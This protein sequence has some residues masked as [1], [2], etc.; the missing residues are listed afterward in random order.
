MSYRLSVCEEIG[1]CVETEVVHV[2]NAAQA[3]LPRQ[4]LPQVFKG[5]LLVF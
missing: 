1:I 3:E 4:G 5:P 2:Q